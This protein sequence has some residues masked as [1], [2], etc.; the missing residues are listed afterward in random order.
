MWFYKGGNC[1]ILEEELVLAH[2]PHDDVSDA[3]ANAV[4]ISTAPKKMFSTRSSGN[5][6][7]NSRFGG[8]SF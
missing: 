2:P 8:I 6:I 7:Y 4:A 5:I 3:L 1:Q